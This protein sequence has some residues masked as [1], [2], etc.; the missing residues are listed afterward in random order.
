MP[1]SVGHDWKN[2]L[3]GIMVP[4]NI[5]LVGYIWNGNQNNTIRLDGDFRGMISDVAEIKAE[6]RDINRRLETLERPQ[7]QNTTLEMPDNRKH[8]P[9]VWDSVSVLK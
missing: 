5:A 1:N 8:Y 4:L 7:K 9:T 2:W 3:I 6:L